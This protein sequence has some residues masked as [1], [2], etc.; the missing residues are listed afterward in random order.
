[1][2]VVEVSIM[3][4][5]AVYQRTDIQVTNCCEQSLEGLSQVGGNRLV[6]NASA[7]ATQRD[8]QKM[9][10]HCFFSVMLTAQSA[11]AE[12]SPLFEWRG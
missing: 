3:C 11:G 4:D 5:A 8:R 10:S 1:M 6:P 12:G 2:I 9:S 7:L